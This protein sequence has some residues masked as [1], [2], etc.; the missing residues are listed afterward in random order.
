ME[1]FYLNGDSAKAPRVVLSRQVFAPTTGMVTYSIT[2]PSMPPAATGH[3]LGI[4]F[5]NVSPDTSWLEID[6]VQFTN[7]DPTIIEVANYSFEQPDSGKIGGFNGPGS[8]TKLWTSQAE[9]PGWATDTVVYD[10]GIET[11][12]N[13]QD[14]FYTAYL[15]GGDT[16]IWNTTNYTI[17]TGDIITLRVM[18]RVGWASP[19]F[20]LE[21][22]YV[23]A[24]GKRV[25][26]VASDDPLNADYSWSEYSVGFAASSTPACVGKKLGVYLD[27]VSPTSS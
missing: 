1:I 5:E 17:Q 16:G 13:A 14:G 9:I 25:T 21:L 27:N 18:G 12:Y 4:L 15:M 20:H 11:G 26:L 19:L 8:G 6:N 7:E 23:N 10:S 22:Y 3:K 24:N 2:V